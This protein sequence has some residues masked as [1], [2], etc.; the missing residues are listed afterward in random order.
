VSFSPSASETPSPASLA[1]EYG[2]SLHEVL[3]EWEPQLGFR[4]RLSFQGP[5]ER[6]PFKALENITETLHLALSNVQRHAHAT[7]TV[8]RV[9]V[10]TDASRLLIADNGVGMADYES[11]TGMNRIVEL[12]TQLGGTCEF[13]PSPG[14]GTE[15]VWVVPVT[16]D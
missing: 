16:A 14:G 7:E 4:P 1:G 8:I 15:V 6:L 11:A 13:S 9:T 10:A 3:D 2:Q 12:A 5:V